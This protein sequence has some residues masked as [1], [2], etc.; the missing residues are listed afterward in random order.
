MSSARPAWLLAG[1]LAALSGCAQSGSML[2]QRT[3]VGSLKTGLSHLEYEN[4]Q[5][6]K[7]A[8]SLKAENRQIEDR[9]VQEESANGDL[10]ARLDDAR[11][12]LSRRGLDG[13]G[14]PDSGALDP[15]PS[16]KALPAGQSNRKRRKTPFA[17]IPGRID[18]LPPADDDPSSPG[19][20]KPAPSGFA[21]PGPTG[22]TDRPTIW[23]PVA[24]GA[25]E[26]PNSRR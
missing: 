16:R 21:E 19:W 26:P 14:E 11:T 9:L 2:T 18:V 13:G 3:N 15:G 23:L 25:T 4:H 24:R 17:Q 12:L 20:G 6:K 5:L 10:T 8:A 1:L 22:N 7:E